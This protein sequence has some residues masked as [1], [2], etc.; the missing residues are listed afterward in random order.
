[1]YWPGMNSAPRNSKKNASRQYVRA[2]DVRGVN[3]ASPASTPAGTVADST[4][5]PAAASPLAAASLLIAA[6]LEC[7]EARGAHEQETHHGGQDDD[8]GHLRLADDFFQETG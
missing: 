2:E 1:M 4:G 7:E 3:D 8:L 5:L 6:L